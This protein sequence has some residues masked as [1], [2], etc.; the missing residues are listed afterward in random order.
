M[1]NDKN[2]TN[3]ETS[4]L[5]TKQARARDKTRKNGADIIRTIDKTQ[6]RKNQGRTKKEHDKTRGA[7]YNEKERGESKEERDILRKSETTQ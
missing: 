6:N 3:R 7:R 1:S 2:E 4:G 5:R